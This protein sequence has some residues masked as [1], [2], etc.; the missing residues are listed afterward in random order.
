M[1]SLQKRLPQKNNTRAAVVTFNVRVIAEGYQKALG[2][3]KHTKLLG[4]SMTKSLHAAV[5]GVAIQ[6]GIIPSLDAPADLK[7]LDPLEHARLKG[8]N[9]GSPI[10]IGDLLQMKDILDFEENYAIDKDVTQMLYIAENAAE[11]ASAKTTRSK[12]KG[13]AYSSH[14]HSWYY[15]S[16]LSNVLAA[17]LRDRFPSSLQYLTFPQR[18][19]FDKIGARSFALETDT[20]GTFT[21]SSYGYATARDW[22]RLGELFLRDGVWEENRL[23]PEGFVDF[24]RKSTSGSG[25]HYGGSFWT[26]PAQVSVPEYNELPMDHLDKVH[27]AWLT[28]ALPKDAYFMGGYLGQFVMIIPSEGLVVSRLGFTKDAAVESG[29]WAPASFFGGIVDCLRANKQ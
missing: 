17:E 16:G 15:S 20:S 5:V 24:V 2:V 19:L 7:Y 6:Q 28:R 26:N 25:G 3:D 1:R 23:L 18:Q 8:L 27:K 13:A 14:K 22:A 10:S 12:V 21:A 9:E 11:F 4:W 29:D